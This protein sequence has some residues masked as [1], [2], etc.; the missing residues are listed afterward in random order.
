MNSIRYDRTA[1]R[2]KRTDE[3][4][5]TDSPIVGRVGI[6]IYINADGTK[7]REL[8]PPEEVFAPASLE[9]YQG[10]P[11]TNLHPDTEV[12]ATNA[13]ALGVG[14]MNTRG[15]PDGDNVTVSIIIHDAEMVDSILNGGKRELSLGYKVDLD[16]TPGVWNGQEY[17]VVQRNIRIN[18]LA[19]VPR[20]RAGYAR[21]NLDRHDAVLFNPVE[22]ENMTTE[23]VRLDNGLEYQAAP[24]VAVALSKMRQ[25]SEVLTQ[26][27]ATLTKSIDAL[28]AERDTLKAQVLN[29]DQVKRDALEAAR[30]EVKARAELEKVAAEFKID[31]AGKTDRQ[32]KEA[33]VTSARKD[34]NLEGKSEDYLSAAFDLTVASRADAAI[35]KQRADGVV[36]HTDSNEDKKSGTYSGF[37]A[38]LSAPKEGK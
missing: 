22:E 34:A 8:R 3:G 30:T 15:A 33:V 13:K 9:T 2:A 6:Q 38:S 36:L 31:T 10:K 26:T 32:I 7:R 27:N 16:E 5:L 1:L 12:D 37:M 20:G 29:A 17:D 35:A 14:V 23:K 28:S 19:V 25:D 4:Y 24:E 18:H 21:L 11:I